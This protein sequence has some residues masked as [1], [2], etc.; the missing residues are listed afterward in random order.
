MNSLNKFYIQTMF[1]FTSKQKVEKQALQYLDDYL[2]LSN[3]ISHESASCLVKIPKIK[4]I[5]ENSKDWSFYMLL[6]HLSLV[7][8]SISAIVYQ[9]CL[10]QKLHGLALIDIK[11]DVSPSCDASFKQVSLF[12]QTIKNH[13]YN[14]VELPDN[15]RTTRKVE[16]PLLGELNAH[17]W[18]CALAFHL[19][20]HYKQ[21]K[22]IVEQVGV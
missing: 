21:A 1:T 15:L 14:L 9:L 20:E 19:K 13:F 7:N 22:Y 11:K 16:H 5:D 2:E 12:E 18:N 17:M 10:D 8:S 4:G 6:E 3:S